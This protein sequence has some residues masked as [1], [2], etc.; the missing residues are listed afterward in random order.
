MVKGRHCA[1]GEHTGGLVRIC[2]CAPIVY[3]LCSLGQISIPQVQTRASLVPRMIVKI[4]TLSQ[5]TGRTQSCYLIIH[6]PH[7]HLL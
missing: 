4:N 2:S 1:G 5:S 3:L 6:R 7:P